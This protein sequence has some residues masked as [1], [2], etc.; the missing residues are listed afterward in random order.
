MARASPSLTAQSLPPPLSPDYNRFLPFDPVTKAVDTAAVSADGSTYTNAKYMTTIVS[1]ASGD[2]EKDSKYPLPPVSPS[3]T[4]SENYGYGLFQ[5]L[6][7][8]G[9][10]FG[11]VCGGLL[12]QRLGCPA[13]F[14]CT[15]VAMGLVHGA[16]WAATKAE[17]TRNGDGQLQGKQEQGQSQNGAVT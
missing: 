7:A 5:A 1:G 3:F 16:Y 10:F 12:S 15:S 17:H 13:M 4:G 14:G 8:L 2:H 11:Q 6:N 9:S